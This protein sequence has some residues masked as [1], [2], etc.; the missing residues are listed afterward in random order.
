[1]RPENFFNVDDTTGG[2]PRELAPGLTTTV[3]PGDQAMIS[4]VRFE[5]G[6][7][8]ALHHHP[9]EQWGHCIEGSG[10]RFQGD[11]E[12]PVQAGDFWRTPGDVPHTMEAGPN[13]L[14]VVDV[15]A[16]PRK[17]YTQPGSG[18]GTDDG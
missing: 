7:R 13:G 16:P 14:V 15:F 1:M 10:T 6:K 4:I 9:E 11:L 5:P 17:A 18:F 12:V 2:I 3:F 8:G